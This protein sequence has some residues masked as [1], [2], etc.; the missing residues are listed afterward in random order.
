MKWKATAAGTVQVTSTKSCLVG[1][2]EC[3]QGAA[4]HPLGLAIGP[5]TYNP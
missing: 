2:T 5:H 1:P 4:V 3:R